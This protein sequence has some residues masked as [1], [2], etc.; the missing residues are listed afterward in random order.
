MALGKA[1]MWIDEG[2]DCK[3]CFERAKERFVR[4]LEES[5]AK[6]LDASKAIASQLPLDDDNIAEYRRL[7]EIAN[8]SLPDE[9]VTF[10]IAHDD[11]GAD[12]YDQGKYQEAKLF[13]LAA[14]EGERRVLG[15]E[16]RN[17]LGS[18]SN[19]GLLM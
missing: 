13:W 9:A 19:I 11:L 15:E 8:V 14:L 4:L 5:N 6:V 3:A 10:D 17:T 1:H 2:D 7:W 18:P 16:H 12:M